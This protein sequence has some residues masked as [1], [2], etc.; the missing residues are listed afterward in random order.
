VIRPSVAE[1]LLAHGIRVTEA[2]RP[3][4]VREL[5]N[6]WYVFE[7]REARLRRRELERVLGPQPLSDYSARVME[8]RNRYRLL[9]LPIQ[10]WYNQRGPSSP[11]S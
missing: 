5:L 4:F 2:T 9:S 3:E 11:G 6:I 10:R 8:L 7:I 1:R